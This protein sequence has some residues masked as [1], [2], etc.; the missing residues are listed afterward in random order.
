[1]LILQHDH[2][3][4]TVAPLDAAAGSPRPSGKSEGAWLAASPAASA[5]GIGLR[6]TF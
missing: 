6:V 5:P 3:T 1:V 4:I 2:A